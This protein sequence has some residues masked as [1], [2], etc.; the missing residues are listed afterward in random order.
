VAK[1]VLAAAAALLRD[2]P[3][4]VLVT[5]SNGHPKRV[6]GH[7]ATRLPDPSARG[8]SMDSLFLWWEAFFKQLGPIAGAVNWGDWDAGFV[9]Q[10]IAERDIPLVWLDHN[11]SGH[12]VK[13]AE[14]RL[15][16]GAKTWKSQPV[17]W[18]QGIHGAMTTVLALRLATRD[19]KD[20]QKP[21]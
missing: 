6:Y 21:K 5:H 9:L 2:H 10:R 15:R 11:G 4:L 3:R 13:E 12:G 19:T 20:A 17:A 18:Y 16:D 14:A 8:S 7:M 1:Y